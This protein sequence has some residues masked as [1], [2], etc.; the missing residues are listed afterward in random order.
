MTEQDRTRLRAELQAIPGVIRV[1]AAVSVEPDPACTTPPPPPP[2]P[3]FDGQ[4]V[5]AEIDRIVGTFAC[6]ALRTELTGDRRIAVSGRVSAQ[7]DLD[8]LLGE[9]SGIAQV[10]GVDPAV[11]IEP[12]P[13]CMAPPPA[14]P[15]PAGLSAEIDRI[16]SGFGCSS[17]TAGLSEDLRVTVSG[18]VSSGADLDNLRSQLAALPGVTAVDA[19]I[20]VHPRPFCM[21]VPTLPAAA[22]PMAPVIEPNNASRIYRA[23][24]TLVVRVTAT[25][26]YDGYLYVDFIDNAGNIVHLLPNPTQRDNRVRAGQ[27]VVLGTADPAERRPDQPVYIIG[28]PFGTGMITAISTPQPLFDPPRL[29][30]GSRVVDYRTALRRALDGRSESGSPEAPIASFLYLQLQRQAP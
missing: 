10:A 27:T 30:G 28:P 19:A 13:A 9:L 6:A 3:E 21:L 8:R 2:L 25:P 17:L 4:R 1:D 7:P 15:D 14:R 24:D 5:R 18:L 11:A 26:A 16:I 22:G 29:V 12:D 20:E 23:G